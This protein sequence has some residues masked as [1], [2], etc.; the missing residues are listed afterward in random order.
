[1]SIQFQKYVNRIGRLEIK[2]LSVVVIVIFTFMTMD[3]G[4]NESKI[5][6][7]SRSLTCEVC[8][9]TFDTME[10]FKE[11]KLSENRDEGLK[12]KGID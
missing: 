5:D 11:H 2:I 6:K 7:D 8:E 10:S 12:Y 3:E 9:Q 1:M 4:H